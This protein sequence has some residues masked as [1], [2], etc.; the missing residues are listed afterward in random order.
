[1]ATGDDTQDSPAVGAPAS[2]ALTRG[3]HALTKRQWA[4][5]LSLA[6]PV[7]A[8][9]T[10]GAHWLL[11]K[12]PNRTAPML[13]AGQ[14]WF[15]GFL[16]WDASWY[17]DIAV[18]RGYFYVPGQQSSVA[19]FPLYPM[20]IRYMDKILPSDAAI[21]AIFITVLSGFVGSLLLW[22][23]TNTQMD[24]RS[25]AIVWLTMYTWPFAFYLFGV[26]Y[27]DALFIALT[28]GAFYLIEKDKIFWAGVVGAFATACRPVAPALCVG[29]GLVVLQ[30]RGAFKNLRVKDFSIVISGVGLLAFMVYLKWK[31]NDP[32]A[33]SHVQVGWD[34]GLTLRSILKI[35][36]LDAIRYQGWSQNSIRIVIHMAITATFLVLPLIVWKRFGYGYAAYS[37]LV[38]LI[39]AL[40]NS[41]T[42]GL[43][44]YVMAAF[45]SMAIV[46]EWLARRGNKLRW[47][48]LAISCLCM[49]FLAACEAA[50][51]YVS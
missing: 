34:Q 6:L 29:L 10:S 12:S 39:P 22:K 43:G 37:F 32:L 38:V 21:A 45:P 3:V 5:F 49:C 4:W 25:S 19:Y 20:L 51:F 48:W 7:W 35:P 44:R 28:F 50:W 9:A 36:G 1:M 46:G 40:G 42:V 23:W 16:R 2:G 47:S 24:C 14:P 41:T 31:F 26:A 18:G 33:F 27:S 15:A 13:H 30:K 11:Y 17:L 8:S